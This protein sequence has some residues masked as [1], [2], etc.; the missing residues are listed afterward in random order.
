M[1]IRAAF[2]IIALL[3]AQRG[4]DFPKLSPFEAVK[5]NGDVP[6]VEVRG[7]WY[8]LEAID[9]VKRAD[10]VGFCHTTYDE[11]WDKRFEEDLVEVLTTMQHKPGKKVDLDLTDVDTN[12]T[13]KLEGVE[14]TH[15]NR[16][17]LW[18]ARNE[19]TGPKPAARPS[20]PAPKTI[21]KKEALEDLSELAEI[22]EEH[23][24]YRDRV[25]AGAKP[26]FDWRRELEAIRTGIGDRVAVDALGI[27]LWKLIAN[28]GDGHS[29]VALEKGDLTGGGFAPF[30]VGEAGGRFVG[31]RPDRSAFLSPGNPYLVKIDGVPIASWIEA[32]KSIVPRGSQQY[33]RRLAIRN[34]RSIE[35]LRGELGLPRKPAIEVELESADGKN[36]TTVAVAVTNE[37][38][39]YGDWPLGA[40]RRLDGNV[41]YL[42]IA[43][44]KD[45][46]E[47]VDAVLRELKSFADTRGLVIDVR[48]NGGGSRDLLRALFPCFMAPGDPPRVVSV[49][50]RRIGKGDSAGGD[51]GC[52]ADRF[53]YP[54]SSKTW[55]PAERAAIEGVA[56]AFKPEWQPANVG[57]SPWHYFVLSRGTPPVRYERPVVVLLDAGCF[58]ATDIFLG[59]FKGWRNVTLLGSASGGGSGHA[60]HHTLAHSH[61]AVRLSAM[62]SY[63]PDGTLY[64]GHG[65]Q[66]DVVLE[67]IADDFIGK[68]DSVLEAAVKRLK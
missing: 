54:L 66:P 44:M 39:I 30:L 5:W 31:F 67:P 23:F 38:P 13:V 26:A 47:F 14:M 60:I 62:I 64:D 32:A 7:H 4:G 51:E 20:A 37:K 65:I 33:V 42:R 61:L 56:R 12:K 6:D 57:F 68:D 11:I 10:I 34:L 19:G 49:A 9:G 24:S 43:E 8:R 45:E 22:L 35:W 58:S 50:A 63:R 46:P 15:E 29:S 48:G 52:L 41:G 21:A 16:Q 2:T 28:F 3:A 53:M 59:A 17:A 27:Q 1:L 18:L 25:G 40:S 36:R 55:S